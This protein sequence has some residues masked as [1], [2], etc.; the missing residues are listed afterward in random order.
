[1]PQIGGEIEQ[2]SQLSSTFTTE[3]A[4]IGELT[5]RIDGQVNQTWWVGPAAD[6]FREQWTGEFKTMLSR[7]QQS[8]TEA[9]AEV[10]RRREALVQ[11]GS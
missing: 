2:M 5:A 7:L 8:L 3:C 10:N 9:S 1:M 11:S 6:R 4:N